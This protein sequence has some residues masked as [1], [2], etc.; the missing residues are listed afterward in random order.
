MGKDAKKEREERKE[1]RVRLPYPIEWR[2]FLR[3]ASGEQKALSRPLWGRK[4]SER[5]SL[6]CRPLV[7]DNGGEELKEKVGDSKVGDSR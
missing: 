7:S 5:Q 2:T 3:R 6:Q 4:G 1:N